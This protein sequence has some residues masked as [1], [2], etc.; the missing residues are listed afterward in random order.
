VDEHTGLGVLGRQIVAVDGDSPTLVPQQV[1]IPVQA[2]GEGGELGAEQKDVDAAK[3]RRLVQEVCHRLLEDALGE[4][5]NQ[6][7]VHDN[8]R[9]TLF[10]G[11]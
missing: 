3:R 1:Y 11:P 4:V 5:G 9:A 6:V 10:Q 2:T 8:S 7:P